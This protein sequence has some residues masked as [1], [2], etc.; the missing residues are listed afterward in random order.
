MRKVIRFMLY[1]C[2]LLVFILIIA[3]VSSRDVIVI[4]GDFEGAYVT[5]NDVKIRF[6]QIGTGPDLLF[7]HGVPGSIEDWE[8]LIPVL[9][10]RYRLTLYDRP[11]H[12]FSSAE[13]IEYNLEHNARIAFGLIDK[14]QLKD[15]IV[16]GHSYGGSIVMAM[17][18]QKT[19]SVKG[20]IAVGGTSYEVRHIDPLFCIIR[21]PL[22]G[23]GFASIA[24][25]TVGAGMVAEGIEQ[26]FHPNLKAIPAGFTNRR[27]TIWLQTRVICTIAREELN[28]NH[29]LQ[30]IIPRYRDI[31]KSFI[32]IHGSDDL[33]VPSDDSRRLHSVLPNSRL[34]ILKNTGHQ[35][36]YAQSGAIVK[37]IDLMSRI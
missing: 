16:I 35:V 27:K 24:S 31:Q 17:A 28:L 5:I 2:V 20:F 3:G 34:I 9:S 19:L 32:I 12:G 37:A 26:A 25:V 1:L 14:L 23:R 8:S 30:R 6:K 33:L 13:N 36:Q 22:I 21:L 15:V 7:I 11:G 29:D 18:V 10:P 4:P